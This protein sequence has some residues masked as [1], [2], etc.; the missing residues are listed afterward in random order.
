MKYWLTISFF[1]SVALPVSQAALVE[2][3]PGQ[4]VTVSVASRIRGAATATP[5][6]DFDNDNHGQHIACDPAG[7]HLSCFFYNESGPVTAWDI[8]PAD[9]GWTIAYKSCPCT[10]LA[11]GILSNIPCS[12]AGN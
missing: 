6:F 2:I 9:V 7:M 5:C 10:G 4:K 12:G 1:V 3:S 8:V 11:Y